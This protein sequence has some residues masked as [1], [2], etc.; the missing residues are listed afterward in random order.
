MVANPAASELVV[1]NKYTGK[2]GVMKPRK[3]SEVGVHHQKIGECGWGWWWGMGVGVNGIGRE[4]NQG[5]QAVG[6]KQGRSGQAFY[7]I[8]PH[9]TKPVLDLVT[10]SKLLM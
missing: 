4:G 3:T 1:Y 10:G 8:H 9:P 6:G 7:V 5:R 2:G